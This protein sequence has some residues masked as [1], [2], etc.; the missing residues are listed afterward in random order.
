M[1][2]NKQVTVAY[3]ERTKRVVLTGGDD[4]KGKVTIKERNSTIQLRFAPGTDDWQ[5]QAVYIGRSPFSCPPVPPDPPMPEQFR[6]TPPLPSGAVVTIHD[7]LTDAVET[8]YHYTVGISKGDKTV[9]SDPE[10]VN[11]PHVALDG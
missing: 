1:P 4:G 6:I 2:E 7:A 9:W 10:I 3:D 5:F 8:T 11:R